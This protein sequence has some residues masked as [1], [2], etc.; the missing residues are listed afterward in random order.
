MR[1]IL[2]FILCVCLLFSFGCSKPEIKPISIPKA[3]FEKTERFEIKQHVKKPEKPELI[4]LDSEFRKTNDSAQTEYF[5]FTKSDF[6]KIVALSK[7][8]DTQKQVIDN[9]E[10]LVNIKIN[11]INSLKELASMKESLSQHIAV[12][13]LNEQEMRLLEQENYEFQE[14]MDRVF[15]I[16]QGGAIMALAFAL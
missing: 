10:Y 1:N 6:A 12:L 13:Y 9:L 2:F 7:S 5:A 16:V 4:Q 14:L 8:F 3:D 11:Q 15:M